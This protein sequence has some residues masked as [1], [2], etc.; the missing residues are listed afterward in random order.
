VPIRK[1]TIVANAMEAIRKYVEE[2]PAHELACVVVDFEQATVGDGDA[3]VGT[4]PD[5]P[6]S[7]VDFLIR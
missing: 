6:R 5:Q 1:Q 4:D 3:V 7:S 2:E